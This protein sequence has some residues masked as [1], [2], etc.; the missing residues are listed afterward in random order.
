MNESEKASVGP[1]YRFLA[2]DHERLDPTFRTSRASF[3]RDSF[4]LREA[5]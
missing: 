3:C 1:V 2:A 4:E 5:A